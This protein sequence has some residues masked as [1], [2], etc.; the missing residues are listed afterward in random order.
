MTATYVVV[1]V[2]VAQNQKL[3]IMD[4]MRH[5]HICRVWVVVFVLKIK[6]MYVVAV[7][8]VH[9]IM[10]SPHLVIVVVR[11]YRFTCVDLHVRRR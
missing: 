1:R 8:H 5:V 6:L 7:A 10:D 9:R 4:Q 11:R 2:R 3:V